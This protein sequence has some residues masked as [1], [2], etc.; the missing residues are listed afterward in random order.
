MYWRRKFGA[1]QHDM[2][3]YLDVAPAFV[4]MVETSRRILP[5]EASKKEIVLMK[6]VRQA[7]EMGPELRPIHANEYQEVLKFLK[8]MELEKRYFITTKSIALKKMQKNYDKTLKTLQ[9]LENM[10]KITDPHSSMPDD[11]WLQKIIES[12]KTLRDNNSLMQQTK[13]T[14]KI[15][16]LKAE[17]E[18]TRLLLQNIT[19]SEDFNLDMLRKEG[20]STA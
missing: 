14:I 9:V 16:G 13:L 20:G 11:H 7:E 17:L 2:A 18:T 10:S 4:A 3:K 6:W 19:A 8:D 5:Y 12:Q 15:A 1:T